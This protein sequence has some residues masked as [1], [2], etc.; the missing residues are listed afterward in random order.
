[1]IKL[2]QFNRPLGILIRRFVFSGR[3]K[4]RYDNN[5][6]YSNGQIF[7]VAREMKY[8]VIVQFLKTILYRPLTQSEK[9]EFKAQL[10]QQ[11]V[12]TPCPIT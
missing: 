2:L 9:F 6:S 4:F 11:G 3:A 5:P 1:M 12:M 10:A 7:E 8:D